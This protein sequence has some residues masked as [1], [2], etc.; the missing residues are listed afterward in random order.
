MSEGVKCLHPWMR[1]VGF[2]G[3]KSGQE[4]K[5]R[6]WEAEI[7]ECRSGFRTGWRG[8]GG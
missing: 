5:L 8:T 2:S 3:S 6:R 4:G 1:W 7:N